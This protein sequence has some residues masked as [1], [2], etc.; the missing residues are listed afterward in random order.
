MPECVPLTRQMLH[1]PIDLRVDDPDLDFPQAEKLARQKAKEVCEEPM[2]LAWLDR[3]RGVFSP[4]LTCCGEDK[5]TWLLYAESR[6]GNIV[7][8]INDEDYVF[9]FRGSAD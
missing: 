8:S 3:N 2:L 6:G 7:L 5:P 1:N 9:V 4:N